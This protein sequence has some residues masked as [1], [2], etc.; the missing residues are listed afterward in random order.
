MTTTIRSWSAK[1]L[2]YTA[3]LQLVNSILMSISNY[4]VILPNR[5]LKQINA[6]CRS[7]LWHGEIDSRSIG[8]VNWEKVSRPKKEG[9][10]GI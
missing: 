4:T 5:A 9:G 10:L 1:N 2:S 3:R 7:Y 6:V 8:A